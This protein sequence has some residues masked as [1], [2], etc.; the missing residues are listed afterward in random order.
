MITTRI[1]VSLLLVGALAC[2][3][4]KRQRY[5]PDTCQLHNV[6]VEEVIVPLGYGELRPP[7]EAYKEAYRTEFPNATLRASGGCV[8]GPKQMLYKRARVYACPLCN[9]AEKEWL[10]IN[11]QYEPPDHTSDSTD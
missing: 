2:T 4:D 1:L 5:F 11:E 7:T 9:A 10:K 6:P 8:V 3:A